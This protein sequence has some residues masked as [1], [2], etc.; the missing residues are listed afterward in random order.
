MSMRVVFAGTPAITLPTL[1]ALKSFS[2]DQLQLVGLWTQPDSPKGRGLALTPPPAK[3]WALEHNVPVFQPTS[4][5]APESLEQLKRLQPD[6]LLVFAYAQFLKAPVLETPRLGC[7]NLHTSLL[8]HWRGASPIHYSLLYGEPHTG[9]T[10]QK[11]VMA[12]DAGPIVDQQQVKIEDT[13]EYPQLAE[14]LAHTAATI[15]CRQ[16]PWH[17]QPHLNPQDHTKATF[18]PVIKKQDGVANS[19]MPASR[20]LGMIRAFSQWP[21]VRLTWK[22]QEVKILGPASLA[23]GCRP[24]PAGTLELKEKFYFHTHSGT[25]CFSYLQLPNQKP[26]TPTDLLNGRAMEPLEKIT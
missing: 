10:L 6:I 26:K 12:M 19:Q 14:T 24:L 25:L 1:E 7:Y 3:A 9:V 17:E 23:T 22:A 16:L 13:W 8:P 11:M 15:V 20:I 21:S 2:S 4:I 5:N 18:A